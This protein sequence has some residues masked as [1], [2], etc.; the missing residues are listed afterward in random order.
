MLVTVKRNRQCYQ[1]GGGQISCS[2][3]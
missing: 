3:Y 1:D 2:I